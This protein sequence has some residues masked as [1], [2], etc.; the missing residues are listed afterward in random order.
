MTDAVAEGLPCVVR[1]SYVVFV[2]RVGGAWGELLTHS[3]TLSLSHTLPKIAGLRA[4]L[5]GINVTAV[6]YEQDC[7]GDV[8]RLRIV[9]RLW[10][11]N[12]YLQT[13]AALD[14][15]SDGP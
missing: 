15:R 2:C 6:G 14:G 12:I 3:L 10:G 1:M 9:G 13:T 8:E 4:Q 5:A 11:D 7:Q